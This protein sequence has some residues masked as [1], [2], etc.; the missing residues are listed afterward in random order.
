MMVMLMIAVCIA[1][2]LRRRG[3]RREGGDRGSS[4]FP[5]LEGKAI[6]PAGVG[7]LRNSARS[8]TMTWRKGTLSLPGRLGISTVMQDASCRL[9]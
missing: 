3:R 5:S 4:K 6:A 7:T 9:A 8:M 2:G 1:R